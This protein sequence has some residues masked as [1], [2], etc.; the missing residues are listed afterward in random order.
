[1]NIGDKEYVIY[2]LNKLETIDLDNINNLNTIGYVF[3]NTP[4]FKNFDE[5]I[6]TEL[7]SK[8]IDYAD[9]YL[10]DNYISNKDTIMDF[11]KG[12]YDPIL[13]PAIQKLDEKIL[14]YIIDNKDRTL[15]QK[16]ITLL[17]LK[18]ENINN[19]SSGI[20]NLLSSSNSYKKNIISNINTNSEDKDLTSILE[21]IKRLLANN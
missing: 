14:E 9:K 2:N 6:N 11:L 3:D 15:I 8:E 5:K 7:N 1:M 10:R 21:N 20:D 4:N 16:L 17:N 12:K 19:I 18:N 13:L